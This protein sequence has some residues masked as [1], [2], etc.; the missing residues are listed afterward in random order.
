[1]PTGYPTKENE[2]LN[3]QHVDYTGSPE[4]DEDDAEGDD[5]YVDDFEQFGEESKSRPD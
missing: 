5:D 1:M 2:G 3:D 4:E